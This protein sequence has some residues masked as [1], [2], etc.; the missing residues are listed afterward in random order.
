MLRLPHGCYFIG[1]LFLVGGPMAAGV[2][3]LIV[4]CGNAAWW[5]AGKTREYQT[6]QR[7]IRRERAEREQRED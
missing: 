5:L 6:A 1:G 4:A 3:A 2:G 7:R